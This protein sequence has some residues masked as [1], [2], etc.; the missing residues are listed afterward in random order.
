M[1][2]EPLGGKAHKQMCE[3]RVSNSNIV[4]TRR[5]EFQ[6]FI[7]KLQTWHFLKETTKF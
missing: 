3:T 7:T 4:S 1:N 5:T 2:H 6:Q